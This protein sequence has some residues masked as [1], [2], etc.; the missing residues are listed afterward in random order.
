[1][2]VRSQLR[3]PGDSRSHDVSPVVSDH[4]ATVFVDEYGSFGPGAYKAHVA[5]EHI[6][7]LGQFVEVQCA[8]RPAGAKHPRVVYIGECRP[9][10]LGVTSHGA[11]LQDCEELAVA[12]DA[13]LPVDQRTAVFQIHGQ[14]RDHKNWEGNDQEDWRE[15]KVEESKRD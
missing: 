12:T 10:L 1:M 14:S 8:N 13:L 3:D 11:Q 5:C 9:V 15:C 2:I 4:F 7:Q 6:Q